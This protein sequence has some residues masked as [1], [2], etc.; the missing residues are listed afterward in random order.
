MTRIGIGYDIHRLEAGRPLILGGVTIPHTKGFV[1][2]SD[3]DALCHAITDAL[4]GALALGD[5]GSHFPDT[6]P[7]Y[8]GA[9]SVALLLDVLAKVRGLG[10][11]IVNIDSNI[12]AQAPKLRPHI[13]TIRARL[14][15]AL[16]LPMDVISV[17]ARTNEHVGPEGREEA[18][19]T[20][21]IVLL[22][23]ADA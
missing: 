8:K 11:E 2:H 7:Q 13:D 15:E 23:K 17:K 6:D 20:Q 10:W 5:I 3:G 12:I 4:L 14:A 16:S 18:I 21:A 1:A 9:D 19:S 22:Q